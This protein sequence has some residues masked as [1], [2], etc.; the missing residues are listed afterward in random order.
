MAL[1]VA[2]SK[3]PDLDV[4]VYTCKLTEVLHLQP[5]NKFAQTCQETY[6]DD[7]HFPGLKGIRS[8]QAENDLSAEDTQK[9]GRSSVSSSWP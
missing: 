7:T 9:Q 1:L 3:Q 4:Q 8:G 6:L 2:R 5:F